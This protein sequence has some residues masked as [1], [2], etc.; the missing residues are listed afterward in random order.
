MSQR[1]EKSRP[2]FLVPEA[3]CEEEILEKISPPR[4]NNTTANWATLS[5]AFSNAQSDATVGVQLRGYDLGA[6]ETSSFARTKAGSASSSVTVS[7]G[8]GTGSHVCLQCPGA[9][10]L[11]VVAA[12]GAAAVDA[13]YCPAPLSRRA[14][15]PFVV[16]RRPHTLKIH[17]SRTHEWTRA[18][19]PLDLRALMHITLCAHQERGGHRFA[20]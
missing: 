5:C 11:F 8:T 9:C 14:Y 10:A 12:T 7:R 3:P 17:R 19:A 18:C 6:V 1:E 20:P 4:T 16:P 13:R 2:P 15:S